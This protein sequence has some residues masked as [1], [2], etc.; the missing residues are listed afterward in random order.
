MEGQVQEAAE[1]GLVALAPLL[2]PEQRSAALGPAL[3]SLCGEGCD[4]E[5]TAG[6]ARLLAGLLGALGPLD[7]GWCAACGRGQL[8]RLA[9]HSSYAVRQEAV[10][11]VVRLM[12]CS[13][14]EEQMDALMPA[15]ARLCGDAVWSVRHEAA[16]ELAAVAALLPRG[17]AADAV[18]PL[19]A[20]LA[21][22]VSQ[23]VRGEAAKQ[24]GPLLAALHP[25]CPN[26][27]HARR[28]GGGWRTGE[29]GHES[30]FMLEL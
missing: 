12:A 17:G 15:F 9:G 4:E 13:P 27:E 24:T 10:A 7:P 5:L 30:P 25:A 26:G 20:A 6:A 3:D 16:G 29:C 14:P 22:D 18:L 11:G 21:G 2:T 23:W 19:R 28:L 8:L 1:G